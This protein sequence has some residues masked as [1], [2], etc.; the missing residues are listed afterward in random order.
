MNK[1][2][3][4]LIVFMVCVLVLV[5]CVAYAE[6]TT[7]TNES[8]LVTYT[9]G[10]SYEGLPDFPTYTTYTKTNG[11]VSYS[12]YNLFVLYYDDVECLYYLLC[13]NANVGTVYLNDDKKFSS[14]VTVNTYND[15]ACTD[16]FNSTNYPYFNIY[17]CG[18][19]ATVWTL[20]SMHGT[21]LVSVA[22][23]DKLIQASDNIYTD[24]SLTTVFTVPAV[25]PSML[26]MSSATIVKMMM[27]QVVGLVPLVIG[28]V[29]LVTAFWK[30]YQTL[31]VVLKAV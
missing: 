25:G 14:S 26:G 21:G 6:E 13:S 24:S 9:D 2:K 3:K 17:C 11:G 23:T 15:V 22:Y 16:L 29:V 7:T 27:K 10:K 31:R 12:L 5:P 1:Y 18:E 4:I 28:L 19:G 8:S 30:G 20:K